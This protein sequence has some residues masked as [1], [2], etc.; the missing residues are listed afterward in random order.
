M[1]FLT[2]AEKLMA[3]CTL[4]SHGDQSLLKILEETAFGR[5]GDFKVLLVS[6]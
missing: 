4:H 2:V 1:A 3:C 6:L 5:A